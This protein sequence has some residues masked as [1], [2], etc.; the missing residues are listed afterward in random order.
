[1]SD[2]LDLLCD[3][4]R[5]LQEMLALLIRDAG[6]PTA[7]LLFGRLHRL[8]RMHARF[9]ESSLYPLLAQTAATTGMAR[10]AGEHHRQ[11]DVLLDALR[12]WNA[13]GATRLAKLSVLQEDLTRH[14]Q[15]EECSLLPLISTAVSITRLQ[16]LGDA[17]RAAS[18][19]RPALTMTPRALPTPAVLRQPTRC[20]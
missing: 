4:H 10:Q 15:V 7:E 13:D 18:A 3:D 5:S 11:M 2:I 1:M 16:Q 12:T 14:I 8:I 17:Y 20:R 9:E 6:A 19:L